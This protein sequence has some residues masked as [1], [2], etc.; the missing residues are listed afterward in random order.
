METI[1]SQYGWVGWKLVAAEYGTESDLTL[2]CVTEKKQTTYARFP[3]TYVVYVR[4][5]FRFF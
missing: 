1:F 4:S 2:C 3:C 5:S